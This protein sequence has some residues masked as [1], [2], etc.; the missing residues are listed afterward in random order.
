MILEIDH[1]KVNKHFYRTFCRL[2]F[3]S[4]KA[5]IQTNINMKKYRVREKAILKSSVIQWDKKP[6]KELDLVY[7]INHCLELVF[8]NGNYVIRLNDK[9]KIPGS[10]TRVSTLI[11]LLEYGNEEIPAY[12]YIRTIL[13]DYRSSYLQKA[14][15]YIKEKL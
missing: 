6:P 11:R 15:E 1:T 14:T 7:Y 13:A 5:T 9:L 8:L 4:I 3:L 2:L 12:P 10:S